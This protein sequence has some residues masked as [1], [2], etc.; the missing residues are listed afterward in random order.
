[1]AQKIKAIPLST[2][3]MGD[4]L[5][6]LRTRD[7]NY[8]VKT[9]YQLLG[10]FE[11]R[12]V[13]SGSSNNDLRSFWKGIWKLRIPNKIKNFYW[14]ACTESLPTLA[15]LH[16][17]KVINSPLCSNCGKDSETALHTLWEC[18]K[19]QVCWGLSFN[20]LRQLPMR[21]GS[22]I[23]LVPVVRQHEETL[24]LFMVLAW[25]IW[26]RQNKC[27][28]NEQSLPPEKLFDAAESTLKEFQDKSLN[29]PKRIKPQP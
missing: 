5:V 28:L 11:N 23:D 9:G 6:W 17:R 20:K 22:F 19:I 29:R 15:N 4:C 10:E 25:Y 12:E 2:A 8:L 14:R 21:L 18:D 1:M 26:C 7:G 24:E 16:R 3:M 27:H 13:A